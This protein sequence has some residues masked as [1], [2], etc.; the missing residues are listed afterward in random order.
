MLVQ[1][2]MALVYKDAL[3][4]ADRRLV[5]P[6]NLEQLIAKWSGPCSLQLFEGGRQS[7]DAAWKDLPSACW[8]RFAAARLVRRAGIVQDVSNCGAT[9]L[10]FGW[11]GALYGI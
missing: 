10:S 3:P 8:A 5:A 7:M 1:L 4:T 9:T 11:H 2:V 6:T